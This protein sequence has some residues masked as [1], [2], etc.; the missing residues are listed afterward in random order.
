MGLSSRCQLLSVFAFFLIFYALIQWQPAWR[1][2]DSFFHAKMGQ[3]IHE[4]GLVQ[5]FFWLPE[6]VLSDHF[7]DQ[8]LF[9]HWLLAELNA[10]VSPDVAAK[11]LAVF[12]A[13]LAVAGLFALLK[14][15]QTPRAWVFTSFVGFSAYAADRLNLAKA[16]SL[17][18]IWQLLIIYGLFAKRPILLAF[19]AFFY[20]WSHGSWPMGLIILGAYLVTEF[21][22]AKSQKQS[23]GVTRELMISSV[24]VLGG[25]LGGLIINPYFPKNL[26]FYWYQ[27]VEVAV[28]GGSNKIQVGSEWYAPDAGALALAVAPMAFALFAAGWVLWRALQKA[29]LKFQIERA[30]ILIFCFALMSGTFLLTLRSARHLEYFFPYLALFVAS[31]WSYLIHAGALETAWQ[32]LQEWFGA[33]VKKYFTVFLSSLVIIFAVANSG[34]LVSK[35]FRHNISWDHLKPASDFVVG[36]VAAGEMIYNL[37]WDFFPELFRYND[38]NVYVSGLDARF[39]AARD[40]EAALVYQKNPPEAREL[41]ELMKKFGARYLILEKRK[42]REKTLDWLR[43]N[44]D[45]ENIFENEES[46]V[47]VLS[48]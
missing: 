2:P 44:P 37:D 6:T 38:Q 3:L 21:I 29:A 40:F 15:F 36:K 26:G 27:I 19:A 34:V 41:Q 33:F 45:F 48:P 43:A 18:L 4:Q 9:Y 8:H 20:V 46:V 31:V 22:I 30:R 35:Y 12:L 14:Y 47:F 42:P 23:F 28:W 32:E 16:G 39:L 25:L 24:A 7:A 13:A 5:D 11:I 17:A 10:F 1:D